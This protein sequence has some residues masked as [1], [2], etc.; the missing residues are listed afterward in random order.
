MAYQITGVTRDNT[1]NLAGSV[2][3]YLMKYNSGT[4]LF[5][6]I[7]HVISDASTGAFTF[8]A[9]ADNNPSYN[10]IAFKDGSPHTY[11]CSDRTIQPI[12][13]GVQ[14]L[15]NV[16]DKS[17]TVTLSGTALN[18]M[19]CSA[20]AGGG[21][22]SVV[23][24][25]TGKFY[26]EIS[27]DLEDATF[28]YSGVCGVGGSAAE[29]INSDS[30]THGP[31]GTMRFRGGVFEERFADGTGGSHGNFIGVDV[32]QI[33]GIIIDIDND[34]VWCC[35]SPADGALGVFN[36]WAFLNGTDQTWA[37]QLGTP[38]NWMTFRGG[39][40]AGSPIYLYAFTIGT[41]TGGYSFGCTVNTAGPFA[42]PYYNTTNTPVGGGKIF[43]YGYNAAGTW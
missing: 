14:P 32:G 9:I 1:G 3:V 34:R 35:G 39:L 23:S 21:V 38:A 37:T 40:T 19:T 4:H 20:A 5:T 11:D 31:Y 43:D 29:I 13:S 33:V 24:H 7:D 22:R 25:T 30:W 41:T 16:S 26:F 12:G 8:S 27:P 17:S 28:D 6:Q 2:D 36:S 15:W 18:S 10:I 42:N